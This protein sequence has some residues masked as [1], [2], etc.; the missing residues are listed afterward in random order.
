MP[1]PPCHKDIAAYFAR[2]I[3]HGDRNAFPQW[4]LLIAGKFGVEIFCATDAAVCKLCICTK[5]LVH[6]VKWHENNTVKSPKT[7]YSCKYY[8]SC[9]SI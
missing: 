8:V 9:V 2:P 3:F 4:L 5:I 1:C 6:I 7:K